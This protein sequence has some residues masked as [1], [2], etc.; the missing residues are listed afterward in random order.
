MNRPDFIPTTEEICDALEYAH[1]ELLQSQPRG[2]YSGV[3]DGRVEN[4]FCETMRWALTT[5]VTDKTILLREIVDRITPYRRPT[6]MSD[7]KP[8]WIQADG[9]PQR[10]A[11]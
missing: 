10:V 7:V 3:R 11:A 8:G 1:I 9:R 5:G 6:C 2:W 4:A